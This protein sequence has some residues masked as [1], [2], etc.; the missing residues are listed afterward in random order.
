MTVILK[1][2][3]HCKLHT[4]HCI[5]SSRTD[6]C[7]QC[8]LPSPQLAHSYS[9]EIPTTCHTKNIY[10]LTNIFDNPFISG[11]LAIFS[12]IQIYV[13]SYGQLGALYCSLF[14]I[15]RTF[16]NNLAIFIIQLASLAAN[17]S[18][19]ISDNFKFW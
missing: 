19:P 4:G 16:N 11:F 18:W 9:M 1:S 13:S 6:R 8:K 12:S 5:L 7:S 2:L 17:F 3:V 15:K 14:D 10:R